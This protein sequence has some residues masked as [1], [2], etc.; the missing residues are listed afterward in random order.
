MTHT[1]KTLSEEQ[2]FIHD[3]DSD[4]EIPVDIYQNET[5]L[6]TLY[7]EKKDV[8]KIIKALEEKLQQL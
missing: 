1:I 5:H 6:I 8:R 7:L 3:K 4:G 2:I